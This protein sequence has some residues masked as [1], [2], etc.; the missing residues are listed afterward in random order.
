M[1]SI[2]I[3]RD[4]RDDPRVS[5]TRACKVYDPR[6]RRFIPGTTCNASSGGLMLRLQ[7]ELELDAGA[8]IFVAIARRNRDG[9]LRAA[10]MVAA[11][12]V[13]TLATSTG[14]TMV[15]IRFQE[16]ADELSLP[17]AAKAA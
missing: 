8:R 17:V 10:D 15:A 11:T 12:V 2:D 13:R 16:P 7:R 4:R 9:F 6:S 5:V 14:E 3:D 1:F